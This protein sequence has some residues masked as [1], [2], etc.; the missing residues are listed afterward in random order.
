MRTSLPAKSVRLK[1]KCPDDPRDKKK[2]NEKINKKC[3]DHFK[4]RA[5]MLVLQLLVPERSRYP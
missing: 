4:L 5:Q 1:K 2:L 3:R